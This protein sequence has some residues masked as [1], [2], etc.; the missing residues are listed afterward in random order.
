MCTAT[1]YVNLAIFSD[2]EDVLVVKVSSVLELLH[3]APHGHLDHLQTGAIYLLDQAEDR[4]ENVG[5]LE[6]KEVIIMS[7]PKAWFY[8]ITDQID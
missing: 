8:V 2:S 5:I 1:C 3:P 6:T 7:M 4:G